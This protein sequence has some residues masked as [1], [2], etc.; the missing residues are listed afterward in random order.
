MHKKI[1]KEKMNKKIR[2]ILPEITDEPGIHWISG[3]KESWTWRVLTTL[4]NKN[5]WITD[6]QGKP[7]KKYFFSDPATK[8]ESGSS[9]GR[10]TKKTEHFWNL[11]LN[12]TKQK[13]SSDGY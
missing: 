13:K 1:R 10:T 8:R 4:D 2:E 6:W 5:N 11:F 12:K 3:V 9:K 7:Q